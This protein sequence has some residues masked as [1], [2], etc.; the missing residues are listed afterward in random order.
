[1]T[2]LLVLGL[3][4]L[5]LLLTVPMFVVLAGTSFVTFWL[6]SPIPLSILPQRV[7]AGIE[8][9]ALLAIPFF[10]FAANIMGR[11]GLSAR[12]INFMQTLVGHLPGGLG[13]TVVLT[14]VMF[15]SITGSS[16]STIVA[17]GTILYPA[18]VQ[19]GYSERFAIG[20]VT[21]SALI[22]MIVPPS[23]AMIVYGSV[24]NVSIGALF[25]SGIGASLVFTTIYCGYCVAW[26]TANGVPRT[27]RA[28]F[29]QV[30]DA[31][32]D[33]VWGIGMP[34]IILGGIYGGVFTATEAAAVSVIYA[35]F[36]CCIVYRQLDLK[37]LWDVAVESALASARI[38][39]MVA[40]AK[41]FSWL[42]T[43]SGVAAA[44]AEPLTAMRDDPNMLLA[45]VNVITLGSG[46]FIDVF[47]NILIIVPVILATVM[48]AGISG[49][50]LGII[51]V[52]NADIGNVTP[53]FGLNLFVASGTFNRSYGSVVLAVLPWLG[54]ALIALAIITYIPEI[55]LWLPRQL[56]PQVQ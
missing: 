24:A 16:A 52:V 43:I 1:M 56:Y 45:L 35:A 12:L 25:M 54:L 44:V 48:G 8:S 23:N 55:S 47:S 19:A 53:P 14:C 2:V 36:V 46:M 50:H 7:F 10:I 51:M 9:F 5:G 49:T 38:L 31:T 11:G 34:V 18:L 27:K 42:L 13:I 21:A 15:G 30:V 32:L 37:G 28:T 29:R 6:T 40:A 26:A 41:L 39:I 22:G 17:V 4:A 33:V 20:V 3:L